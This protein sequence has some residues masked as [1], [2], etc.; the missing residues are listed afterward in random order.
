[1]RKG[2][3]GSPKKLIRAE[4]NAWNKGMG[5]EEELAERGADMASGAPQS[6]SAGAVGVIDAALKELDDTARLLQRRAVRFGIVASAMMPVAVLLLMVQIVFFEAGSLGARVCV[7]TEVV[8]LALLLYGIKQFHPYGGTLEWGKWIATRVKA[9]LLRRE[10]ALVLARAGEYWGEERPSRLTTIAERRV[11]A[12]NDASPTEL[13][14]LFGLRKGNRSYRDIL[15]D[16]FRAPHE[17]PWVR[18]GADELLELVRRY[19]EKRVE[20]QREYFGENR[21]PYFARQAEIGAHVIWVLLICT[22]MVSV[23]HAVFAS[24]VMGPEAGAEG[25]RVFVE[26]AA[27]V[28]PPSAATA[29]AIFGL[30]EFKRRAKNCEDHAQALGEIL[31]RLNDLE[32]RLAGISGGA[33]CAEEAEPKGVQDEAGAEEVDTSLLALEFW[34]IVLETEELLTRELSMWVAIMT[35]GELP[36]HL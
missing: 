16:A 18:I 8:C 35:G 29:V 30:L 19:K 25:T 31:D 6:A 15:E 11:R 27:V 12:M 20:D 4:G 36:I 2:M 14:R 13:P 5:S 28:L 26:L 24:F 7:W 23:V 22:F 34:R 1:M 21:G 17:H 32:Q 9:E 33:G 3:Y 10:R